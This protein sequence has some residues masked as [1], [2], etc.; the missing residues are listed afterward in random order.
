MKEVVIVDGLRSPYL[1]FDTDFKDITAHQ[2]GAIVLAE[3]LERLNLNPADLDEVIIGNV[4]QP[5]EAA[6]IARIIALFAGV[7]ESVP[8]FS[9]QRNCSS[10]MQAVAD[11]WYRIQAGHGDTYM[12]GGVESMSQIPLLWN[13]S[14]K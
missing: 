6:N 4:A 11:A 3:L 1:K 14:A 12:T 9:V 7:P 2:L 13:N 5:P 8:A 10:G